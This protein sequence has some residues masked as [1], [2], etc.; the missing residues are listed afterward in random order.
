MKTPKTNSRHPRPIARRPGL[1]SA[2]PSVKCRLA[3]AELPQN[4]CNMSV[5]LFIFFGAA[6]GKQN[7]KNDSLS[8]FEELRRL[9]MPL[10]VADTDV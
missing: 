5:T 4:S 2:A 8:F 7:E 1:P 3:V 9:K 6:I 10:I